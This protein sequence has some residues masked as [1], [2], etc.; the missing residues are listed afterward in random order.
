MTTD[1]VAYRAAYY[2]TWRKYN[3]PTTVPLLPTQRRLRALATLGWSM[4]ALHTKDPTLHPRMLQ[5]YLAGARTRGVYQ[6]TAD[7]VGAL[8]DALCMTPGPS[9][10]TARRAAAKGWAPPLAYDDIDNPDLEPQ[11]VGWA[12]GRIDWDDLA[13]VTTSE[14]EAAARVGVRPGSLERAAYRDGRVDVLA[15]W[16]AAA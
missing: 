5:N 7:R 4:P 3:P 14:A 2:Q 9:A 12:P 16:R 15:R 13:T 8:Y 6:S 10:T 11:G 1:V